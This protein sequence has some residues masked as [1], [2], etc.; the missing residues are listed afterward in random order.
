M[1]QKKQIGRCLRRATPTLKARFFSQINHYKSRLYSSQVRSLILAILLFFLSVGGVLV[2]TQVWASTAIG[3]TQQEPLQLV[4][5]AKSF[6]KDGQFESALTLWEQVAA[7]FAVREDKLNQAMALSNLALTAQQLGRWEQAKKAIATSLNILQTQPKTPEQASAGGAALTQILSSTL[8]IQGQLQLAVGES[9]AALATWKQAAEIYQNL[10]NQNGAI[11]NQ[12]NQTQAMQDLGLYPMACK[13]L[14]KI[15]EFDHQ[16][17][18]ITKEELQILKKRFVNKGNSSSL[19]ILALRSLGNVLRVVSQLEQS[20]MVLLA[21]GQLAQQSGDSQNLAA[22]YLSLGNTARSLGNRKIQLGKPSQEQLPLTH[23][24]NCIQEATITDAAELYQQAATCYRQAESSTSSDIKR[25]AQLNRFSLLVQTQQWS[26]VPTLVS[27]ITSNLNNLPINHPTVYAHIKFVQ[28]LMCLQSGLSENSSNA[29]SPILQLCNFVKN[30]PTGTGVKTLESSK[31]PSWAEIGQI[32]QTALNQAQR[33]GDKQAEA[34]VRGY[35][36]G[37]YLQMGKL[38]E[39][40]QFTEQALQQ[41]SAFNNSS[42]TYLWQW[43]LGRIYHTQQDP[44]S[45]LQAYTL[46]YE[47]LQSLRQD[48]VGINPEIQFTFRDSVEPVYRELV[49]LLLPPLASQQ[50][51]QTEINQENL[52][53]ARDVIEA[54]Q[55]AEL[56][57]F[58]REA[59]ITSQPQP[60][61]RLDPNAAVI[62][63]IILPDRLVVILSRPQKDLKYYATPL[64]SNSQPGEIGELERVYND[65]FAGFTRYIYLDSRRPQT[66]F[67]DWLIR[68]IEAELQKDEIKTLVFVLDGVLRAVPMSALYDSQQKKYLIEKYNLALS[69]GLQLLY[70]RSLSPN[71]LQTL[72]GGLTEARQGFSKLPGVKEE[73]QEITK[74][75]PTEVLLNQ[76]F[77]RNRL[78]VQINNVSFPIVHLATHGQFSSQAD[79]TFLLTWDSRINVKE[80]DQLLQS[81]DRP[82]RSPLELLI[83]SACQTAAGDNRAVLGLAGVAVRSGARST[84]ATLWS[85]EDQSTVELMNKFYS[86]LNQPGVTKAEA[87]RQAQLFLLRSSNYYR[88]YYWAPF[89]L[90]GNWL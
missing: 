86:E 74:I 8:D 80:L 1:N 79:N 54:L 11:R 51:K 64:K 72:V 42:I 27:E 16:N 82:G 35:L 83:L 70:S 46:A 50:I 68:P 45:A 3:Q 57:N 52:K 58:F 2:T 44:K 41:K 26:E 7:A 81:R 33:L 69:P 85:V 49:N 90:V 13:T 40:R 59:C 12:I 88:P 67:Y 20:Q 84:L 6:Y 32:L 28:S 29:L 36:G 37:V 77:T 73:V 75:V 56:T 24:I 66:I 10:S 63:S 15:L 76:E 23:P 43:Q 87:L 60:I 55:L 22:T 78:K 38:A 30:T 62:Y 31:I 53:L 21:A 65:L 71:K 9:E 14:L 18:Q 25:Q 34:D 19:D 39:A 47:T 61:D 5:E 4:Q 89:V 48:L 17:C